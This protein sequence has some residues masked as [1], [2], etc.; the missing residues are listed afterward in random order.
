MGAIVGIFFLSA[1]IAYAELA[2]YNILPKYIK[3]IYFW[4]LII[5]QN[6][7]LIT[8]WFLV[9][10]FQT[11]ICPETIDILRETNLNETKGFLSTYLTLLNVISITISIIAINAAIF[12]ASMAISA[13]K[14][15][16]K[17]IHSI[18]IGGLIYVVIFIINFT[19]YGNRIIQHY[20]SITRTIHSVIVS[21]NLSNAYLQVS[22]ICRNVVATKSSNNDPAIIV[23]LGESYSYFHS[24][25][26]DYEKATNPLLQ[27]EL[28]QGDLTIFDNVIAPSDHTSAVM[29]SIFS[30]GDGL[31][32]TP[33]FPACLKNAGYRTIMYNNQYFIGE[34]ERF[35]L[36]DLD[37]SSA[38]FS[39]RNAN[40]YAFDGNLVAAMNPVDSNSLCIIHLMGQHYGYEDRYPKEFKHFTADDYDKSKYTDRQREFIAHYDNAT[41]YNDYVIDQIIRKH[42]DK[43]CILIYFS[44][45]GEE[46]FECRDYMGH[47]NATHS[48][49]IDL[50]IKV[51]F[52]IWASD[53]YQQNYPDKMERIKRAINFPITTNDI[54]HF[55]LDLADIRTEWLDYSR[56]FISDQYDTTRHRI[57]L[58]SIDYDAIK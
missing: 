9:F 35:F 15:F 20:S 45:H 56:S 17:Y 16:E 47:G 49:N 39:A 52:M 21:I 48:P 54:G 38:M 4:A 55:L 33:L 5:V 30:V 50:Q 2:V 43:N 37:I 1:F 31:S 6:I 27:N 57:V 12:F 8:D 11:L 22:D 36:S 29:R 26:Y 23:I 19:F 34:G 40:G 46:V 42:E 32:N 14:N 13:I 18:S 51:P 24:S 44:D 58:N 28:L 53:K 41:L 3:S 10:N 25:L 7:L